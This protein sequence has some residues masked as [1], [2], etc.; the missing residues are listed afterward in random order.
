MPEIVIGVGAIVVLL[1]NFCEIEDDSYFGVA[2]DGSE[3]MDQRFTFIAED[4][5]LCK[6]SF[7]YNGVSNDDLDRK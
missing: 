7:H 2:L 5:F 6:G 4:L 1:L 3:Q